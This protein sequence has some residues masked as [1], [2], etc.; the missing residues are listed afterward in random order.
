MKLAWKDA[1][2]AI[3]D[4]ARYLDG[5]GKKW[6]EV[7]WMLVDKHNKNVYHSFSEKLSVYSRL[8]GIVKLFSDF[9]NKSVNYDYYEDYF[10]DINI[11]D[12]I[13]SLLPV[14]VEIELCSEF[15]Q[16]II[17]AECTDCIASLLGDEQDTVTLYSMLM[18][19]LNGYSEYTDVNEET[20]NAE[21]STADEFDTWFTDCQ[22]KHEITDYYCNSEVPF[23][24]AELYQWVDEILQR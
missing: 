21:L 16:N 7:M 15:V 3:E 19:F 5:E 24:N 6:C 2:A 11:R 22:R 17:S 1:W 13:A 10:L 20:E 14:N 9:R 4:N 18:Y 23:G 12:E 8:N